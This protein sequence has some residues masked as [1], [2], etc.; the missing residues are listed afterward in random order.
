MTG[1]NRIKQICVQ[2][3]ILVL[4]RER[5]GLDKAEA[6][7]IVTDFEQIPLFYSL[8][9]AYKHD[10]YDATYHAQFAINFI[11]VSDPVSLPGRM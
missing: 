1:S 3:R 4:T 7:I 2:K 5:S 10:R 6:D 9:E 8:A 11:Y